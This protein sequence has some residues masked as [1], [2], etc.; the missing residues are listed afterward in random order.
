MMLPKRIVRLRVRENV[1]LN[2]LKN[3]IMTAKQN[4]YFFRLCGQLNINDE[5]LIGNMV[6]N[7]TN[8]RTSHKSELN[9]SES[10]ALIA[11]LEHNVKENSPDKPS[12]NKQD[13][14]KKRKQVIAAIFHYY[15]LQGRSTSMEHVKATACQ[16]ACV[17]DFNKISYKKLHSIYNEFC[18]KQKAITVKNDL[19]VY[20]EF[21]IED[22]KNLP[23]N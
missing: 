16:A 9:P 23:I 1:L 14:D 20:Y 2:Y 15:K 18:N 12:E 22:F 21:N 5:E 10:A 6:Y 7:F 4:R 3:K 19:T 13:M 11:C 8:G 17:T